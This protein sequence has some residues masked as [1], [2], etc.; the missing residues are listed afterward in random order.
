MLI[1]T[2]IE[3]FESLVMISCNANADRKKKVIGI[4]TATLPCSNG[5]HVQ[6]V[7]ADS[8]TIVNTTP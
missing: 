8:N 3:E 7:P 1:Y 2:I 4:N 5:T 6:Q